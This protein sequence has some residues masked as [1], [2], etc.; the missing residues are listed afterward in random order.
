MKIFRDTTK[1]V[2]LGSKADM[3]PIGQF[4]LLS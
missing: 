1:I 2:R 4:L 3:A